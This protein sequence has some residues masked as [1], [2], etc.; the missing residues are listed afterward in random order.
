MLDALRPLIYV[1]TLVAVVIFAQTV[2]GLLLSARDRQQ[3]VNRRL[4]MLDAGMTHD[5]VYAALVRKAPTARMAGERLG[6]FYEQAE[7]YLM[8]AG[9]SMTPVQVLAIAGGIAAV[10]WLLSLSFAG[11]G[12]LS[13]F[14]LNGSI[15]L[16]GAC[17]VSAAGV[18]MWVSARRAG[19]IKKLEMQLPSALDIVNRAVRAG[20]PVISAVHLASEELG[21]PVGSEFG[22]IVDETTYGVE[23]K[24]ALANFARRTGSSDGHFFAVCVSIQSET[25]GNLAEILEGLASVMRGRHTLTM[26][27]KAL[28]SEGRASAILLSVLPIFV[29]GVQLMAHPKVY[30]EKFSDPIF[31]PVVAATA[32]AYMFGWMM[33]HRI[34]NF[35]Y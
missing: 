18:W 23:F 13:G 4:T 14:I 31:W 12:T 6:Q 17:V 10:L 7:T 30:S 20:H 1:L 21:D 32:I 15:S 28:A 22:L 11:G 29:I 3:R 8:Q 9:L 2:G 19:R 33:V 26:R 24:D 25:G 35:K 5:Q 34:I 27:V 16:V